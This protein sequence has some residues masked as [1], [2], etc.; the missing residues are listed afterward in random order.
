SELSPLKLSPTV[1]R[2]GPA[3]A[4]ASSSVRDPEPLGLATIDHSSP[5]QCSIRLRPSG[6]VFDTYD[7]PTAQTFS[8]P[9]A[10]T[11]FNSAPV[12]RSGLGTIV[13]WCPSQCSTSVWK[14]SFLSHTP[15]AQTSSGPTTETERRML[16]RSRLGVG[17]MVQRMPSQCSAT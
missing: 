9:S 15:T 8:D 10:T 3:T 7:S 6:E 11:P 2:S 12:P 1:Q 5:S 13:H 17:T 4:T 16:N 14:S